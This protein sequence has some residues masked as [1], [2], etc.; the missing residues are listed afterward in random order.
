[1]TTSIEREIAPDDAASTA[2]AVPDDGPA[3]LR[4]RGLTK[5]YGQVQALNGFDLTA[6]PGEI[7]GLVG[8]NGSGKTTFVEVVSGLVRP[9]GGSVSICGVDMIARP[10]QAR[11]HLGLAPQDVALYFSASVRDNLLLFGRLA[12]LRR[13]ALT[14]AMDRAV[15]QMQLGAVLERPVGILSGG[16]RRRTQVATALLGS[17]SLLLLDEPTAGADPGTREALLTAVKDLA[18]AGASVVYTTHY[19]PELVELGASLAVVR[20]G[21]V[22]ARGS[23]QALL[24]GLPGEIRVKVEGPVPESLLDVGDLADGELRMPTI[25]PGQT[26]AAILAEGVVPAAVDVRKPS[27]DD[28]Y[29]SLEKSRDVPGPASQEKVT[30]HAAV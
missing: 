6:R 13:A 28:L 9:D 20:A 25:D 26:L 16:Q 8:A 1:M 11:R 14:A 30:G 24:A 10:R 27:L 21:Q 3:G 7:V 19:L 29:H 5:R 4:V 15:G 12:G 2:R 18:A 22:I 17:P 23:Q